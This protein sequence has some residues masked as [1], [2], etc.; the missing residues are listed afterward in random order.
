LNAGSINFITS[1]YDFNRKTWI[2]LL[3]EKLSA[4]DMFR[5]F[6]ALVEKE[7]SC[8]NQCFRSDR[9][10]EFTSTMFNEL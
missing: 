4:F 5:S 8:K 6:K 10:G 3:Q 2:Y 9:G 7:S 1:T